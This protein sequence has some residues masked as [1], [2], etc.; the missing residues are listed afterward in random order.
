ML[1][2]RE[3]SQLSSNI[4]MRLCH[5]SP[6]NL[7]LHILLVFFY[8]GMG[9]ILHEGFIRYLLIFFLCVSTGNTCGQMHQHVYIPASQTPA[10]HLGVHARFMYD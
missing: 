9:L 7:N 2:E 3:T 6:K 10:S 4:Q 5:Y 8:F 1:N